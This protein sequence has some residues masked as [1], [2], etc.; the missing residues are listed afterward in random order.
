MEARS[1]WKC[2]VGYNCDFKNGS[3]G[4]YYCT[5]CNSRAPDSIV[6]GVDDDDLFDNHGGMYS[7]SNRR[8]RPSQVLAPEPISQVKLTQ[9]Q[10]L[11]SLES[12]GAI[13]EDIAGGEEPIGL[14]DFGSYPKSLSYEDYYSEIRLRY[15]MGFQIMIQLQCK[16]LVE[17]FNVSPLIV[18]LVGPIWLRYLAFT[19][20]MADE[21]AD[22]V[23]HESESQIQ[24]IFFCPST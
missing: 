5:L 14:S 23:I 24:G 20:V 9:S 22:E 2:S 6:T 13:D 21:W 17:K 16:A 11:D 7:A 19:R 1:Q 4:F 3:D 15:V 12:F 18:G 8:H 10:H